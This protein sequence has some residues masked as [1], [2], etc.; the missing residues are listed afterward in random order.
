MLL[1]CTPCCFGWTLYIFHKVSLFLLLWKNSA[2]VWSKNLD[3]RKKD[4]R[5]NFGICYSL[6]TSYSFLLFMTIM[7]IVMILSIW[8]LFV[9]PIAKI[10]QQ[11]T[12]GSSK[13]NII[14]NTTQQQKQ[15]DKWECSHKIKKV[16]SRFMFV[17]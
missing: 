12:R 4:Q 16:L 11:L 5:T 3:K 7:I 15:K 6:F 17:T 2:K 9:Q 1:N 10:L 14:V 13:G 8:P